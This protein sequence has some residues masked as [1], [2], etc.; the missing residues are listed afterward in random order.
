MEWIEITVAFELSEDPMAPDL[1]ADIFY[2][3]GLQGVVLQ[4]PEMDT[5][6]DWADD[7]IDPPRSHAVIGYLPR[8][9]RAPERLLIIKEKLGQLKKTNGISS[10]VQKTNVDEEDWAESWKAYFW[11]EKI[12]TRIV[13]K[14]TWREYVP[15]ENEIILEIDPGMAFG[16]GT[17]PTTSLCINM[18][19]DYL[20]P[21]E[22]MLDVGTGSGI[23]MVAA[24][25]LEAG[26]L[27]GVDT[28]DIATGIAMGNLRLNRIPDGQFN[29]TTGTLSE[30]PLEPFDLVVANILSEIIVALA[31]DVKKVLKKGGTFICSGIIEENSQKVIKKLESIGLEILEVRT[32][33]SWVAIAA[34]HH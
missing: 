30:T 11:P 1:I 25:K 26:S 12:G 10:T 28:D 9:K 23:L 6:E 2:D 29:V 16:T 20:K 3:F 19:E 4:D 17:H 34:R 32:R 27:R 15:R 8:D 5:R 33:E 18:I 14:P 7:A 13:V 22:T 31:D 24:A 21:G